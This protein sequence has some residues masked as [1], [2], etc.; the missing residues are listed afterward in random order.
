MLLEVFAN[1]KGLPLQHNNRSWPNRE[2]RWLYQIERLIE[3]YLDD[4]KNMTWTLWICAYEYRNSI[5][6][7][8]K[9]TI[10]KSVSID[11]M[12][13][14]LEDSLEFAYEKVCSWNKNSLS[15]VDL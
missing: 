10:L 5:R 12:D 6:L 11:E 7:R 15:E 9:E 3:I 1:E 14:K 8:K 2:F 13:E 4:D